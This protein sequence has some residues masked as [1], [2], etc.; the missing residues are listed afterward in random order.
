MRLLSR[1]PP[2]PEARIS[3]GSCCT[4][5]DREPQGKTPWGHGGLRGPA[6]RSIPW[7]PMRTGWRHAR[8]SRGALKERGTG[9]REALSLVPLAPDARPERPWFR[10]CPAGGFTSSP[11]R[12]PAVTLLLWRRRPRAR[13]AV[14]PWGR[15]V[16]R[17]WPEQ[18]EL[19][20]QVRGVGQQ[21]H[22]LSE[23][24]SSHQRA[25][26]RSCAPSAQSARRWRPWTLRLLHHEDT[27]C[28]SPSQLADG[29]AGDARADASP[30]T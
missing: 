9:R 25:I 5:L 21:T 28:S 24:L 15:D 8:P 17:Y 2:S 30:S 10:A 11:S 23:V 12:S 6:R 18:Q 13:T 1:R 29:P 14:C 27:S 26:S 19:A 20:L 16:V 7:H 4:L 22:E 3:P